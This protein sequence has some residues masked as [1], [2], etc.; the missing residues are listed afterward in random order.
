MKRHA[1]IIL[2]TLVLPFCVAAAPAPLRIQDDPGG[3][4]KE[5]MERYLRAHYS[6]QS[7]VIDGRCFAA[8]TLV[9]AMVE[10]SRICVTPRAALGF[11]TF[12]IQRAADPAAEAGAQLAM[13]P[14][15]IR[16]WITQRGGL[17]D[18]RLILQGA[19]LTTYY[20]RCE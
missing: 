10:R 17:S 7:V 3:L 9:V 11:R 5:Y 15:A 14:P 20:R 6:G 12:P 16:N 2:L 8:C 18:A 19:E 13:Y 4:A 1:G